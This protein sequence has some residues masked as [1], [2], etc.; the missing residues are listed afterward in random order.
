MIQIIYKLLGIVQVCL[1]VSIKYL[2]IF[3]AVYSHNNLEVF[4][5]WLNNFPEM[6]NSYQCLVGVRTT[7]KPRSFKILSN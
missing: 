5:I 4:V 2:F 1:I 6:K 3:I 7:G